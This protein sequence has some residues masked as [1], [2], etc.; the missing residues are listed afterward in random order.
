MY[1]LIEERGH[2][3]LHIPPYHCHFNSIEFLWPQSKR[4]YNN[5]V[6]RN[7]KGMEAVKKIW[8]EF[9]SVADIDR[10]C[11]LIPRWKNEYRA[12]CEQILQE[13]NSEWSLCCS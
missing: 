4:Y 13:I 10:D 2:I 1:V 9:F 11:K 8:E 7:G 3:V 5:N 6:I 12:V